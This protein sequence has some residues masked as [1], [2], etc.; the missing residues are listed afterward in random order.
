MVGWTSLREFLQSFSSQTL[1]LPSSGGTP[2]FDG[3]IQ[4]DLYC[5]TEGMGD[6]LVVNQD[7]PRAIS[8]LYIRVE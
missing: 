3:R 1:R 7:P 6:L 5:L 8:S 4:E 2:A